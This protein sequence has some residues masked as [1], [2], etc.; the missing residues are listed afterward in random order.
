L[1]AM[2]RRQA[3]ASAILLALTLGAGVNS[4]GSPVVAL[5]ASDIRLSA[6]SVN[7]GSSLGVR[8]N[9]LQSAQRC[10]LRLVGLQ[11]SKP[12]TVKVKNSS[13]KASLSTTG[14]PVGE[15]VVRARC[16]KGVRASSSKF[17]VIAQGAPTSATCEV[18]ESGF[19]ASAN[20]STSYGAVLT[21]SSPVLTANN[22]RLSITFKD[23]S[24]TTLSTVSD[25][26]TNIN[27]GEKI[28]VGMA[29]SARHLNVASMAISTLCDSTSDLAPAQLSGTTQTIG[30]ANSWRFPTTISGQFTNTT[31]FIIGTS[32]RIDYI[33]RNASGQITAGGRLT[34][35][36]AGP[37]GAVGTW[38]TEDSVLPQDISS[39]DWVLSPSQN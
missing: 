12:K 23:A 38:I 31:G 36:P 8:I 6:L 14:L 4:V 11:S 39:A 18:V 33:S 7:Q 10:V 24:G 32:S 3:I 9:R 29:Y 17:S 28:V 30:V 27:P 35:S 2:R 21:N 37:A 19:S 15:Y 34:Q 13:V 22:V 25:N 16:G 26:A 20:Y 1:S 5:G